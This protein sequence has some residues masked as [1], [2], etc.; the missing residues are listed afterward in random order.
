MVLPLGIA[1]GSTQAFPGAVLRRRA[2]WW[3]GRALASRAGARAALASE[4]MTRTE[5]QPRIRTGPRR[6]SE[7]M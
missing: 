7:I 3:A 1:L 2:C 4:D 6:V 5:A